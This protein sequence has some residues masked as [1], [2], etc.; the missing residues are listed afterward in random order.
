MVTITLKD[1]KV[2]PLLQRT[3]VMGDVLY[4]GATPTNV[5]IADVVARALHTEPAF[6]AV[7]HIYS[8]YGYQQA[9]VSAFVY[10]SAE[11]RAKA[12]RLTPTQKKKLAE[13]KKAAGQKREGEQ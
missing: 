5:Q 7:N 12:E 8:R 10:A 1:K 3:E 11:A 6:V 2:N 4:E 13:E 9:S